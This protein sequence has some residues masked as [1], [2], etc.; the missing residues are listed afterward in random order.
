MVSAQLYR[1]EF[2]SKPTPNTN[3]SSLSGAYAFN[4]NHTSSV[5][6]SFGAAGHGGYSLSSLTTVFVG[7]RT[8]LLKLTDALSILGSIEIGY[9]YGWHFPSEYKNYTTCPTGVG[10]GCSGSL[11]FIPPDQTIVNAPSARIGSG[12]QLTLNEW[13][14]VRGQVLYQYSQ[15]ILNEKVRQNESNSYPVHGFYGQLGV[16]ISLWRLVVPVV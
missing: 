15:F 4:L 8:L 7:F 6:G 16:D 9:V 13:L 10:L 1:S 11:T 14:K 12:F 5:T 2:S 3:F